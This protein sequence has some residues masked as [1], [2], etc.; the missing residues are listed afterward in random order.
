M[1]FLSEIAFFY[2]YFFS[3]FCGILYPVFVVGLWSGLDWLLM[4]LYSFHS[5]LSLLDLESSFR[6]VKFPF[7][8]AFLS[9]QF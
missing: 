5:L 8:D 6:N 4:V 7:L 1:S 3:L 9:R 2:S